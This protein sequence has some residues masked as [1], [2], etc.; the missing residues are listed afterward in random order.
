[1]FCDGFRSHDGAHRCVHTGRPW[2]GGGT[3]WGTSHPRDLMRGINKGR[4]SQRVGVMVDDMYNNSVS[5]A[6]RSYFEG[7]E[8]LVLV[9]VH[10][11]RHHVASGECRLV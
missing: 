10:C 1:M 2:R 9:V 7:G 6:G 3:T 5:G 11:C 4:M 8:V